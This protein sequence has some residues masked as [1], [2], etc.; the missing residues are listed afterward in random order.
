MEKLFEMLGR[1]QVELEQLNENYDA[2]LQLLAQVVSGEVDRRRVL[3]NLTERTWARAAEGERPG[4]PATI[5]GLPI[6]V[7]APDE[8]P[9]DLSP[10]PEVAQ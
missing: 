1:K 6:C 2:V 3:V 9:V 8:P 10:V 5:N 4:T 7:V